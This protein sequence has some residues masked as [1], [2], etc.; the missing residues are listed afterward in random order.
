MKK[1]IASV[2]VVIAL[3][4]A[5]ANAQELERQFKAAVNTETVDGDLKSAIE[6][7]R[8]IADTAARSNRPL[9]AQA[10]LRAAEAYRALG[11]A[12]ARR[13]Y[14]RILRD[15]VD[16]ADVAAVARARISGPPRDTADVRGDRAV[17]TG[18][19][20]DLFGTVSPDG[21][22]LTYVDWNGA[23][24]VRVRDL[25]ANT[26]R[27]LTSNTDRARVGVA[28][29][30]AV[31]RDG[32]QVAYWWATGGVGEFRVSSLTASGV[33]PFRVV[34]TGEYV[35]PFDWSPDNKW[36]A[37][38]IDENQIGV[39]SLEDGRL[40][41]LKSS[42]WQGI[43]YMTFSPDGRFIA[44]DLASADRRGR[45]DIMVIAAD[46][47]RE[48]AV[49]AD[50]HRN[51]LMGW[52]LAGDLVFSSDRSGT[53]SLWT[54]RVE[55]GRPQGEARL[56]KENVRATIPLG[57]TPAGAL[58]VYQPASPSYVRIAPFDSVAGKL[59]TPN[60]Q[61]PFQQYLEQRGRPQWAADS[62][63]LMFFS[64]GPRN[65]PCALFVRDGEGQLREIAHGMW[66]FAAADLSPDGNEVVAIGS[67]LKGRGGIYRID[68]R[69]GETSQLTR[70][71]GGPGTVEWV[72]TGKAIRYTEIDGKEL[73]LVERDLATDQTKEIFRT[74]NDD[75]RWM[76]LSP[77]GRFVGFIQRRQAGGAR[78]FSFVVAPVSGGEARVLGTLPGFTQVWQWAADSQSVL[79]QKPVGDGLELWQLP[80][81]GEARRLDVDGSQ[82]TW[83][84][85]SPDGKQIAFAARAGKP[86]NE[87]WALENFLPAAQQAAESAR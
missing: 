67:D 25:I 34:R 8:R 70:R 77:D 80:L 30:S 24:N 65:S 39:V 48:A 58:Y 16:Q 17:W 71:A 55:D 14:E 63:H 60:T 62:R 45:M 35:R 19:D 47:S 23:V 86:G 2:V 38:L 41:R 29:F 9:A 87:V 28:D 5:S 56:V 44:Y 37:A 32:S 84:H 50:G 82:W 74:A 75:V 42:D 46:G 3:G 40:R 78:T 33:P 83:F 31:S 52:S 69:T 49:V 21:R 12:E 7:Y 72:K 57:L 51:Y 4:I 76:K 6:Q 27:A 43:S 66:Y 13:V 61:Q 81:A 22:F 10:L 85:I 68:G 15:Y 79:L 53:R 26:S 18:D 36:V 20:V 1:R 64:C 11:D 59:L 73:V 54:L